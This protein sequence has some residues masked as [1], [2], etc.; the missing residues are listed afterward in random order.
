MAPLNPNNTPRFRFHYTCLGEDHTLQIRSANS[1]AFVGTFVDGFLTALGSAQHVKTI[2]FVE[3]APAG[4]DIFNIVVT[5]IESNSY[6]AGASVPEHAAWAYTFIG[7]T[8]GGKRV[9]LSVYGATD[10][11]T[12]YRFIAGENVWIDAAVGALT[13]A[14]GLVLGID[15]LT[16]A[17]KP[18]AN[19]Q[20][21]DHW[22]KELRP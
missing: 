16:P 3:W 10:L 4:S 19:I 9:R 18:Y 12:D 17:W 13:A 20:V 1:P 21:N 11:G 14:G 7:R 22:V 8:P 2:S 5:G 15:G 6:G